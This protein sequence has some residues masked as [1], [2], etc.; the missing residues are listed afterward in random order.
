MKSI[1]SSLA[2]PLIATSA[3]LGT[4]AIFPQTALA[5]KN[6]I[7][8]ADTPNAVQEA[9]LDAAAQGELDEIELKHFQGQAVYVAEI[10]LPGK[11]DLDV[12]VTADGRVVRTEQEIAL[13]EL[14]A[15]V[16]ST[17]QQQVGRSGKLEDLSRVTVGK[18]V[19]FWA[20]I[21]LPGTQPKHEIERDLEIAASGKILSSVESYDD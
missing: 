10:D 8:L 18:T 1:L 20:E 16:R 21:E 11:R 6:E 5:D 7:D 14:P 2:I 19:T 13:A 3:L 9:V 4:S 12:Y 15:E 17:L